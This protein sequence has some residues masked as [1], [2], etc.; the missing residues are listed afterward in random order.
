ML[1]LNSSSLEGLSSDHVR[2]TIGW[3]D[4]RCQL[5]ILS[6]LIINWLGASPNCS[7]SKRDL[8]CLLVP[9][10]LWSSV[11]HRWDIGV[12]CTD[13]LMTWC[14]KLVDMHAW[15][16]AKRYLAR[17]VQWSLRKLHLNTIYLNGVWVSLWLLMKVSLVW[18][19]SAVVGL[20][21]WL[22]ALCLPSFPLDEPDLGL[23]WSR[24]LEFIMTLALINSYV[25]MSFISGL[26]SSEPWNTWGN[27]EKLT[28]KTLNSHVLWIQVQT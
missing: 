9:H 14:P 20:D 27:N 18:L 8:K 5:I 3:R 22:L 16:I 23:A 6:L 11:P 26:P 19:V 7:L 17:F 12:S 13:L 25:M 21:F 1:S 10:F 28:I 24:G 15:W 4:L 2:G